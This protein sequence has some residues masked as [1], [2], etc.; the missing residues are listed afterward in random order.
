M[1][2]TWKVRTTLFRRRRG[3][4]LKKFDN[5]S[6]VLNRVGD[7]G[8]IDRSCINVFFIGKTVQKKNRRFA[9]LDRSLSIG[10]APSGLDD[11]ETP[12]SGRHK[13]GGEQRFKDLEFHGKFA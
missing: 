5:A 2:R 4:L 7:V 9:F 12:W 10:D 1:V 8:P 13:L 6:S 11:F 3:S